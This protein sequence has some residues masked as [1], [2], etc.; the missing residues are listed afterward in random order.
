MRILIIDDNQAGREELAILLQLENYEVIEANNGIQGYELAKKHLPNLIISDI[1]MP[2]L[3][4]FDTI[5]E[6]RSFALTSRIP[7]F[8]LS[9]LTST[10]AHI[11]G[12]DADEYIEKPYEPK[13]LLEKIGVYSNKLKKTF[14]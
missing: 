11:R 13:I 1:I 8:F 3:D 6:I 5:H 14:I 9:A 4:G 7:F 10:T 2:D 12:L